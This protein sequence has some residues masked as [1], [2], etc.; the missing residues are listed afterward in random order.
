MQQMQKSQ[1]LLWN[2]YRGFWSLQGRF[3]WDDQGEPW[4]ASRVQY[5]VDV[6]RGR[7]INSDEWVL[8]AGCGT[9]SYAIALA[10]ERFNVVGTDFATGMLTRAQQKATGDLSRYVAFRQA[11]LNAPLEFSEARFDHL[12][13]IGVLQAVANPAFTLSEFYRVLKPGGTL[14]LSLPRPKSD[15]GS[16]SFGELVRYRLRHL[17][18]RT[19]WKTLLVVVKACGDRFYDNPSWTAS[20]ARDMLATAGFEVVA[21]GEDRQIIVVAEKARLY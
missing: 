14:L 20:Q 11:D 2:L 18:R 5:V 12:I 8:D 10:K 6:L 17:E 15:D 1:R 9:G 13:C 19:P 16:R 7:R 21:V 4:R 3:V